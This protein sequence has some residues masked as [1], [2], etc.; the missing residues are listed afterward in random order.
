M[1]NHWEMR[2]AINLVRVTRSICAIHREGWHV[3]TPALDADDALVVSRV[4]AFAAL[5]TQWPIGV[6]IL[7]LI[8]LIE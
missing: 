3:E 8:P 4:S 2:C 7:D 1:I 6:T 5:M